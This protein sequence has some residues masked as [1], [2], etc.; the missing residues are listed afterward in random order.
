MIKSPRIDR[1]LPSLT[2][3]IPNYNHGHLIGDQL[4]AIFSQ[5]VQPVRI[6]IIDDA[7][8]DDSV[9]VIRALISGHD[10]V[11]LLCG[12][13]N[14]GVVALSNQALHMAET[15]YITFLAAD[16]MLKP[17]YIEKSLALLSQYPNAAICSSIAEVRTPLRV[18]TVPSRAMLPCTA[19][20]YLSPARVSNLLL[21]FDS[22][23]M[24]N[25]ATVRREL[26]LEVGGFDARLMSWADEFI[27]RV[28][29]LR[30]G[31]CFIPEALAINRQY[32]SGY[33][34]TVGRN[35]ESTEGIL[36][37]A[38]AIIK[39]RFADLF[40]PE[41][42]ARTNARLI[43]K[44]TE[45]RLQNFE[46]ATREIVDSLPSVGGKSFFLGCIRWARHILTLM[47]FVALRFRDLPRVVLSRLWG[48]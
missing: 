6:I 16:D 48:R 38:N 3:A 23:I 35:V 5:S 43:Y 15:D 31:A 32:H 40:P 9:K 37:A 19:A 10:N 12:E 20:E 13:R 25:T 22:W 21:R 8:T 29:A 2:I 42:L 36:I 14:A 33:S 26:L 44:L 47:F 17:G 30:H 1:L 24:S 7:S 4:S 46:A 11:E 28:L 18:W 34:S 39:D 41:L 45:V 27:Y